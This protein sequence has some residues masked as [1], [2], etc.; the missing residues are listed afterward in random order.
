[1]PATM[2]GTRT[3][4]SFDATEFRQLA[5][6][7]AHE[8]SAPIGLL[9]PGVGDW[10]VLERADAGRFPRPDRD[11]IAALVANGFGPGRAVVWQSDRESEPLWL[12]LPV[13]RSEGGDLIALAG[14]ASSVAQH[15]A[16]S[17]GPV[18]PPQA[19]RAWGQVVADQLRGEVA[20]K[21]LAG[22][23][24]RTEGGERQLIARLIRRLKISDPPE[25]F[26][27]L[28]LSALRGAMGVEAVA[29]VPCQHHEPVM[30]NGEVAG[31]SA[32]D[33]HGLISRSKNELVQVDNQP[34]GFPALAL[35]RLAAVAA[36]S[37]GLTGWLVALNPLD[38]RPF[39]AAEVEILQPVAS[40]IATQQ[41]NARLYAD[42]KELLFGVIRALTS[43][44]D[45]KDPYT[46]GHSERVARIAVRL[47]EELGMTANQR[48]DLYLMGLLHDVGKIG[49]DDSVLKKT[50]PL[51]P[52]EY[53]LI[54]SH[55]EIGVHILSDLKKLLHL[56]PGIKHHHESLD[57]NGYPSRLAGDAIPLEARIL[58]VADSFDAMSS[59]RPYRKRLTP[60]QIDEIL[61][62]GSG[63][64]WD[65]NVIDALYACRADVEH[66][67]QKGLGESLKVVV[68]DT[69]GRP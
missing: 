37:Q 57:G 2:T 22:G 24:T 17:W 12:A 68:N 30:L 25:R 67:R 26:Q 15:D 63:V 55:V 59:T 11:L 5:A 39:T 16:V 13:A 21:A 31:L 44:I 10:C 3:N 56:L 41:T 29:W 45:A 34:S 69:L 61:K 18:C 35:R 60:M 19:L 33:C 51:T 53:R 52:D 50:G 47:A 54:Q 36:D 27:N 40:L 6:R 4:D 7:L 64:Q 66:I 42:L 46:S 8:F 48:S 65:P 9:D 32:S 1:M 38:G 62:K 43:A 20:S 58:A 23:N 28:A 14:F 49:I